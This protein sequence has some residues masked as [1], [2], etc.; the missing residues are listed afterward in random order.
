MPVAIVTGSGGL[1]GS[2]AVTHFV[3][4]GFDVIGLE[5]DSRARFFGPEA[6]T[7]PVTAAL[8]ERYAA[9]FSSL[10]IDVRD[11]PRSSASSPSTPSGSR[12]WYTRQPSRRTTGRRATRTPTST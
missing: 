8:R 9:E 2:Q 7:A 4:A 5:N 10:D 12:S 11:T 3:E 6:S 1:V